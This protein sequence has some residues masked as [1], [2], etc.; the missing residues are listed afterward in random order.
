MYSPEG[1]A[2]WKSGVDGSL[3]VRQAMAAQGRG[4]GLVSDS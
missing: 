1:R 4:L 2:G 3:A